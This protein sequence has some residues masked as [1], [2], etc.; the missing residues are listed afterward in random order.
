MGIRECWS[1]DIVQD[2]HTDPFP[3]ELPQ[4]AE[5][6]LKE[7]TRDVPMD[8]NLDVRAV[9]KTAKDSFLKESLEFLQSTIPEGISTAEIANLFGKF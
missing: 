7:D 5:I 1:E 9:L 8:P 6:L 2:G 3:W 4:A